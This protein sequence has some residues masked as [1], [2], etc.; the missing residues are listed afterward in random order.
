MLAL[1]DL[2]CLLWQDQDAS[3]LLASLKM[4]DT[5]WCT[6]QK[7]SLFD[8]CGGYLGL[9]QEVGRPARRMGEQGALG[10]RSDFRVQWLIG[11]KLQGMQ[12]AR[13]QLVLLHLSAQCGATQGSRFLLLNMLG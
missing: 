2:L 13:T 9:P 10:L 1:H 6:G 5:L 7:Q 11:C 8:L 12:E 4:K 3:E